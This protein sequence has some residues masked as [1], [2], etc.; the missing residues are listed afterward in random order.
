[1]SHSSN[2]SRFGFRIV[3]GCHNERRLVDWQAAFVG[4]SRCDERAEVDREAYLSAFCFGVE[5][6]QH[7]DATGS[8]KN[9]SGDCW[10]PRLWFDIDR[11]DLAAARLDC[12]K[13]VD[14]LQERYHL[15]AEFLLLFFSGAKGFHVGLPLSVCGSPPSMLKFNQVCRKLSERLAELAGVTID[16][17]VYDKVRAFRAPNSRHSKTGLHKLRFD[18]HALQRLSVSR[19]CELSQEARPFEIPE[20][21]DKCTQAADDWLGA[22]ELVESQHVDRAKRDIVTRS[23]LNQQ[24]LD[25]IRNGAISG[26]RHRL[27][28][29]A[30]ANLAELGCR[31]E[32]AYALLSEAALDSGLSP[33]DVRRQIQC[34]L[35]HR[36]TP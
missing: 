34:G 29:S 11:N 5:F 21:P 2:A 16:A 24:T 10:S 36:R 18:L 19:L 28:F 8:T 14:L 35:D 12:L 9:Y 23:T 22:V 32:L 13:L 15:D 17:G 25:F 31:F 26:D 3:G 7:L 4:Y 1:M 30:A 33:S 6:R 20:S 27:L